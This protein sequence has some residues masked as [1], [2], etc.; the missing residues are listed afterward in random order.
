MEG[1]RA[2]TWEQSIAKNIQLFGQLE[3]AGVPLPVGLFAGGR[4]WQVREPEGCERLWLVETFVQEAYR[5]GEGPFSPL[6]RSAIISG[7]GAATRSQ[8]GLV[9]CQ[10]DLGNYA[11]GGELRMDGG[12]QIELWARELS[13]QI[14]APGGTVEV[15]PN[16]VSTATGTFTV[17]DSLFSIAMTPISHTRGK[18]ECQFTEWVH[19]VQNTRALIEIPAYARRVQIRQSPAGAASA[20]WTAEVTGTLT[21]TP[22]FNVPFVGRQT[23]IVGIGYATHL[24]SDL[25]AAAARDFEVVYFMEP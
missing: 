23:D 25:D 12:Q 3:A 6:G 22:G 24:R 4:Q 14:L 1:S 9:Q 15:V 2:G 18:N 5:T 20:A 19:V 7:T 10:I 8:R 16:E 13:A 17:F 11:G 21:S